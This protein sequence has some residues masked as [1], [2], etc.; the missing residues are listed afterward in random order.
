MPLCVGVEGEKSVT[1]AKQELKGAPEKTFEAHIPEETADGAGAN[2]A[3]VLTS[4]PSEQ[5][6]PDAFVFLDSDLRGDNEE[7]GTYSPDR[8]SCKSFG[9]SL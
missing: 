5:D 7:I 3:A 2:T 4:M 6:V 9:P 1:L 8:V